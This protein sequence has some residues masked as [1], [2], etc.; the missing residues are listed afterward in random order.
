[1]ENEKL[2]VKCLQ[3]GTDLISASLELFE[4]APENQDMVRIDIM[5]NE[6]KIN[7]IDENFFKALLDVRRELEK[8]GLLIICNGAAENVYPSPMQLSMGTGRTAYKQS[9]KQQARAVDIVDIFEYD[10][11]LKIVD[12]ET[13]LMYH[14]EWLKSI[15]G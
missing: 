8:L 2:L 1:M 13:Q 6:H 4:E 5:I 3:N 14:K 9:L 7:C 11:S 10:E 15:M 12:I